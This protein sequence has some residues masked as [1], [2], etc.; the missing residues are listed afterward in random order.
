MQLSLNRFLGRNS[1][2][3]IQKIEVEKVGCLREDNQILE[4]TEMKM[5]RHLLESI[6]FHDISARSKIIDTFCTL[7]HY[8]QQTLA[9]KPSCSKKYLPE[10]GSFLITI[11]LIPY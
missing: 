4:K 1:L 5:L 11:D 6:T 10:E 2:N 7:F 8:G 9:G 3:K